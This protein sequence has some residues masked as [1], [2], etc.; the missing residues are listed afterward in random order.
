M[1]SSALSLER[2]VGMTTAG[3]EECGAPGDYLSWEEAE[4]TLHSAARM[5]E[6]EANEGPCRRE[7][8][9]QVFTADFEYH[10]D[11]MEHCQKIGGGRS[12]PVV[13]LQQWETFTKEVDAI[14]PDTSVLSPKTAKER[15]VKS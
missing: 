9:V 13:T 3:G 6:V 10:S 4:W 12:P 7:S 2:M 15:N 11:C 5:L 1:F 14:T 8:K